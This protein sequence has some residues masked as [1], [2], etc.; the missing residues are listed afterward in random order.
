MQSCTFRQGHGANNY[1]HIRMYVESQN[2]YFTILSNELLTGYRIYCG[3]S[4]NDSPLMLPFLA[5]ICHQER[6]PCK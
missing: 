2:L 5:F 3:T 1:S 4:L 6:V